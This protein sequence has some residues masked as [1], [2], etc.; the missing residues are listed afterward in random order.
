MCRGFIWEGGHCGLVI[1][2]VDE[3]SSL[4]SVYRMLKSEALMDVGDQLQISY[5]RSRHLV[6][7]ASVSRTEHKIVSI[8]DHFY[9][10]LGGVL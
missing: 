7:A 10:P 6:S 5:E 9:I 2:T 8:V 3:S 1:L 4:S